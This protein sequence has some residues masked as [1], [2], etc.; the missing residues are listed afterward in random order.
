MS[1]TNVKFLG[2]Y[3]DSTLSWKY[4]WQNL[5]SK[6]RSQNYLFINLRTVLHR[7]QL[8]KIYFANVD[9]LLR[10]GIFLWG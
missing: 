3:Y 4:H 10:Y 9:S 5:V 2:I 6:F 7:D 1:P 8:I